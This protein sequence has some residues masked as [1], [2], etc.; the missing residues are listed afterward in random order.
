MAEHT[1]W[2]ILPRHLEQILRLAET[3]DYGSIILTFQDGRLVQI[4]KHEK[5]RI[6]KQDAPIKPN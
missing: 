6:S 3:L 1:E 4:D 2:G 5:M